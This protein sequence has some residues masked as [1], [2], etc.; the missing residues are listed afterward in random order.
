MQFSRFVASGVIGLLLS[1]QPFAADAFPALGS[2]S[3]A[4]KLNKTTPGDR[5]LLWPIV[6]RL[7]GSLFLPLPAARIV[8]AEQDEPKASEKDELSGG[9]VEGTV[10]SEAGEPL[11]GV[12]IELAGEAGLKGRLA[13]RSAH[14]GADGAYRLAG[15]PSG[16]H[17]LRAT[18]GD[19]LPAE[20]TFELDGGVRQADWTLSSGLAVAGRIADSRGL[21]VVGARILA[22]SGP[23]G[24]AGRPVQSG[25]DGGFVL[26][27]VAPG[28]VRLRGEPLQGADVER[29][30]TLAPGE[31]A[32]VELIVPA[33]AL[34]EGRLL[35]VSPEALAQAAVWASGPGGEHRSG[36]VGE[37][38]L[39]SVENLGPGEWRVAARAPG[40]PREAV[41][42]AMLEEGGRASLD[43]LLDAGGYRLSGR[44]V[45]A[46]TPLP[47]L[48]VVL[49]SAG[50]FAG[51]ATTGAGGTF[52]IGSLPAG[53]YQLLLVGAE[54]AVTRHLELVS[55]LEIELD[56]GPAEP[57]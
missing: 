1:S 10:F 3:S 51:G 49:S 8:A 7:P 25:L 26:Q 44:A 19:L 32:D 53:S 47:G 27:G 56:E 31:E 6:L 38:G 16:R 45:R 9:V 50:V 18:R 12:L 57:R 17:L 43:L 14:S 37:D 33:S 41:G 20:E 48:R 2:G 29:V 24:A 15:L 46:G 28:T 40:F 5:F 42:A 13:A 4:A 23:A 34:I 30:L 39:Y 22:F 36:Y 55:D 52:S 35:G 54:R 11:A 21:P